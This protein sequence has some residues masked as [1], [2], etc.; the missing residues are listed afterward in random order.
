MIFADTALINGKIYSVD[1]NGKKTDGDTV[2]IKDGLILKT[3]IE[4]D[5]QNYISADT[6]VIDCHGNT[7]L[8]GLCDAHCH[9]S[10]AA[11]A[12]SGCDLFGIYIQEGESGTA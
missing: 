5:L 4:K 11:S 9:P 10:I 1:K 3:G 12:Y 7:I 6:E 2:L 8:P